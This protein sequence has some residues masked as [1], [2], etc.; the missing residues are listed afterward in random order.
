MSKLRKLS[1][2][3]TALVHAAHMHAAAHC[4]LLHTKQATLLPVSPWP[5]TTFLFQVGHT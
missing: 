2:C 1:C 5:G 3:C 4:Q